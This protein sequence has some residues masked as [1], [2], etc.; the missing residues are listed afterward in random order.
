QSTDTC[1]AKVNTARA[2]VQNTLPAALDNVYDQIRAKAPAAKVVVLGYPRFYQLNGSC[3]AGLAE[4][5]RSAIN[6]AADLLDNT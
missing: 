5:E 3:I 1:V 6:G 2:Y 4:A